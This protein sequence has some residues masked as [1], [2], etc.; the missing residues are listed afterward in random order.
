MCVGTCRFDEGRGGDVPAQHE[1]H[2][3]EER[4][5]EAIRVSATAPIWVV[6]REGV[7]AVE[8]NGRKF[9]TSRCANEWMKGVCFS[10]ERLLL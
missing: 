10:R 4:A 1:A 3:S 7:Q 8:W 5:V 2:S 9:Q 6:R